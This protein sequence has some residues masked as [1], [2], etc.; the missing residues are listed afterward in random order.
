MLVKML[1]ERTEERKIT[2]AERVDNMEQ[3][4]DWGPWWRVSPR[5]V[6][7]PAIEASPWELHSVGLSWLAVH[8]AA[9]DG[10][11]FFAWVRVVEG[12]VC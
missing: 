6:Q 8:A 2:V 1:S 12:E 5:S 7:A 9:A 3:R 4:P 11:G 10:C